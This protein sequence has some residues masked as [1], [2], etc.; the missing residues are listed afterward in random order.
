M[1]VCVMTEDHDCMYSSS[2][3]WREIRWLQ[4]IWQLYK[5]NLIGA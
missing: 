3:T 5:T 1:F 2:I 4:V